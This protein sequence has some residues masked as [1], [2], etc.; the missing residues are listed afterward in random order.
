M[1]FSPMPSFNH[2]A[3]PYLRSAIKSTVFILSRVSPPSSQ[4]TLKFASKSQ[5]GPFFREVEC[6]W[7][8]ICKK[9]IPINIEAHMYI[10]TPSNIKQQGMPCT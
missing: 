8:L 1:Q 9:T 5:H 2:R 10:G 4:A 3:L 6:I 7:I